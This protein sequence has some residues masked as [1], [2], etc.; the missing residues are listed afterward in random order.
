MSS[1]NKKTLR[2]SNVF[3]WTLPFNEIDDLLTKPHT[4]IH[5]RIGVK[6][7]CYFV[8]VSLAANGVADNSHRRYDTADVCT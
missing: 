6:H 4:K 1:P 8:A 2:F 5:R 7:Y 3:R